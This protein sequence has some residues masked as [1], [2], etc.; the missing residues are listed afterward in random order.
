MMILMISLITMNEEKQAKRDALEKLGYTLQKKLKKWQ[1]IRRWERGPDFVN[2]GSDRKGSPVDM[3]DAIKYIA[4]VCEEETI[5]AYDK[6]KK[7]LAIRSLDAQKEEAENALYSGGS[8]EAVRQYLHQ[9]F[10]T[11]GI[12]DRVAKKLLA[13]S[14]K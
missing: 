13:I 5:K 14:A 1:S 9:I 2:F 4:R 8:M 11:A 7:G 12:Q 10:N 3:D 6:S